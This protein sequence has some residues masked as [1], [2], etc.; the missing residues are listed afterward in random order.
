M[1][2]PP[3]DPTDRQRMRRAF[4]RSA[5]VLGA[6]I[7][8]PEVWGWHGR[9]LSV[10]VQ[11]P[12]R[13]TC[14]LR[15]LSAPQ[16]KAAGKIWDGNRQAAVLFDGYV[17]KPLLYD[18]TESSSDGYAYRSELHQYIDEPVSSP[19]PVLRRD[20]N[21]PPAW[22]DSLRTD[23]DHVSAAP[24]NRMAVRQ[25]WVDRTVPRFLDVPG[26]RITDWRTAH[27]DLHTANLTSH[28]PYLLDWEGFG[29]APAGYDAAMLLA[30]SLLA[31]AFARRVRDTFPVL[32]TEPGRIAQLVVIT[33]LLQSASRGDHPELVPALRALASEVS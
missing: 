25:E 29:L 20:P 21:P 19:S 16:D 18:T 2:S 15:L 27:G 22:W 1:Y 33:E 3:A 6:T 23:L 4:A 28:T 17:N 26:P 24:V 7:A 11:H 5:R 8:G 32:K 30:Y 10:R 9:T 14:W 13:G 31:P 12:E